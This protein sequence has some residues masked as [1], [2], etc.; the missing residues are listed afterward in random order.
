MTH[1]HLTPKSVFWEPHD[2]TL[3]K[4]KH[5]FIDLSRSNPGDLDLLFSTNLGDLRD[6]L[7]IA[8]NA[9]NK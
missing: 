5:I 4:V 3:D 8:H 7:E 6:M 9:I 2:V 1:S